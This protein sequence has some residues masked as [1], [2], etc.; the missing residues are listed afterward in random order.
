MSNSDHG[1]E[2]YP[3]RDLS[4]SQLLQA[5]RKKLQDT[6]F[7]GRHVWAVIVM[8]RIAQIQVP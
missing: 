1:G 8:C 5:A 6:L 4:I 2:F 3:G 7:G